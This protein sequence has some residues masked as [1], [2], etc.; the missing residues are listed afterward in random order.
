MKVLLLA[1]TT[2]ARQ[3]AELLATHADVEVIASLAGHTSQPTPLP[4][5]VRTGGFGGVDG[6]A[7]YLTGTGIDAL[8]DASHPFARHMP[9]HAVAAA[10]QAGIP[11]L[12]VLRPA[13]QPRAGD[14]WIDAH[15]LAHAARRVHELDA[16]RVLLTIGRPDLTA[17]AHLDRVRFTVRSIEPP[18]P[19]PLRQASVIPARGPFTV[20][21]EEALLRNRRIE[22]IVTKNSGGDDAKLTAGRRVGVPVVMIR[23]PPDSNNHHVATPHAAHAWVRALGTS[24]S[25]ATT[26]STI[27]RVS[28]DA[29]RTG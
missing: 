1:G 8:V 25:E 24:P 15:D 28:T 12:R 5:T 26:A 2:E 6:L 27:D 13:W 16:H 19:L 18:A 14:R 9:R 11:H 20:D 23:R 29:P 17:F 7:D 22:L 3:L 4:C 21:D 10:R